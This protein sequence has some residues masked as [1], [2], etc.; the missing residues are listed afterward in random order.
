MLNLQRIGEEAIAQFSR[1]L[2]S[3]GVTGL[4]IQTDPLLRALWRIRTTMGNSEW[5]ALDGMLKYIFDMPRPGRPFENALDYESF[6]GGILGAFGLGDT[7][8]QRIIPVDPYWRCEAFDSAWTTRIDGEKNT[9]GVI[10]TILY[11]SVIGAGGLAELRGIA[12]QIPFRVRFSPRPVARALRGLAWLG[13]PKS[14]GPL[15]GGVSIGEEGRDAS[16]T[17]GGCLDVAGQRYGVTCG[18]VFQPAANVVQ[19]SYPDGGVSK[20]GT[21][22]YSTAPTLIGPNHGCT[23]E[24]PANIN[25]VALLRFDSVDLKSEIKGI[26]RVSRIV[27]KSDVHEQQFV[28][29]S[30][31]SG[32]NRLQ[33]ASLAVRRTVEIAGTNYCFQNL[34]ELRRPG[35]YWGATGTI[36]HPTIPGDSGAWV[37]GEEAEGFGWVGMVTA[38]DGPCSYA[39]YAENVCD[40]A[41]ETITLLRGTVVRKFAGPKLVS[42]P[43]PAGTYADQAH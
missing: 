32:T 9:Q 16:G 8:D 11:D 31:R 24:G 40:W 30:A 26:G 37:L 3:P 20:L 35:P 34:M 10:F 23:A 33:I 12:S 2:A 4:T 39:Q 36:K 19:P 14:P 7:N 18:H 41:G 27:P 15:L 6:I 22:A 13:G 29:V 25:D 43:Q 5:E 17:L 38:G 42:L 21:C 28:Q 1:A